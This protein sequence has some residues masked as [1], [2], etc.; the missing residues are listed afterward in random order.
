MKHRATAR[1]RFYIAEAVP[2]PPPGT[3]IQSNGRELG[4]MA[5]GKNGRGLALVRLDRFAE[6]EG[7]RAAIEANGKPVVLRKPDWLHG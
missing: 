1:R 6:A 4:R 7:A 3:A 5:S 2:L